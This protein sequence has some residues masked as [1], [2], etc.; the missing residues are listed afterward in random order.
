MFINDKMRVNLF[1]KLITNETKR[2]ACKQYHTDS[3]LCLRL[4][5]LMYFVNVICQ[6]FTFNNRL[7]NIGLI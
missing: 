6:Q 4:S 3:H 5:V 1:N 7:N 2:L